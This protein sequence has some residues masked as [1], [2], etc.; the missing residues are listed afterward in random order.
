MTIVSKLYVQY[1]LT[2][3]SFHSCSWHN[4][5]A[6]FHYDSALK[7]YIGQET[8]WADEM[9]FGMNHAPDAGSI[10][11][12]L[13]L[14]SSALLLYYD[15]PH[16]MMVVKSFHRCYKGQQNCLYL[17]TL[18]TQSLH[19]TELEQKDDYNTPSKLLR[20]HPWYRGSLLDCWST[21]QAIYPAPKAW[22]MTKFISLAQVVPGPV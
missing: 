5:R 3:K 17:S 2:S 4:G 10:A 21:G 14:Q 1:F 13:D 12:H 6:P 19:E 18:T 7:G 22:F 9:N 8:I 11:R 16:W 20:G 15:C